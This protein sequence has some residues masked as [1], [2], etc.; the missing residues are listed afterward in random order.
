MNKL[1]CL[2]LVL[3]CLPATSKCQFD[4]LTVGAAITQLEAAGNRLIEKAGEEARTTIMVGS[5]QVQLQIENLKIAYKDM[6][7]ESFATLEIAEQRLFQDVNSLADNLNRGIYKSVDELARISDG[8][9]ESISRIPFF[10]K[11]P[12]LRKPG[13]IYFLKRDDE[14]AVKLDLYGSRLHI[15]GN[16]HIPFLTV[17]GEKIKPIQSGSTSLGFNIPLKGFI[18]PEK[19]IKI[20]TVELTVY[21]KEK[22]LFFWNDFVERTFTIPIFSLPNTLGNYRL[23]ITERIETKV[24]HAHRTTG[25]PNEF[26]CRSGR[27]DDRTCNHAITVPGGQRLIHDSPV[28]HVTRREENSPWE[29]TNVSDAGFTLKLVAKTASSNFARKNLNGWVSYKTY[30]EATDDVNTP[31]YAEGKIE[32]TKDVRIPTTEETIGFTLEI[33]MLDGNV[34]IITSGDTNNKFF[35]IIDDRVNNQ[36]IIKPTK[37]STVFE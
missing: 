16:E 35:D 19:I 5:Q 11:F 28:F 18:A 24:E 34:E 26:K 23:S 4:G 32:W 20:E 9:D 30:S 17:N 36:V 12:R 8:L 22:W 14:D 29:F 10:E 13:Q 1:I 3:V 6:L 25:P 2:F 7:G 21:Q 15:Y 31:N 37:P 33:D 27:T